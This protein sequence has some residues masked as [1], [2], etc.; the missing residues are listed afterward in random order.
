[1]HLVKAPRGPA[2]TQLNRMSDMFHVELRHDVF[3]EYDVRKFV[4]I[5]VVP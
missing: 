5:L 3:L 1:M 2:Q 4:L